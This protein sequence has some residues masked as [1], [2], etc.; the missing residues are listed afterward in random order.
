MPETLTKYG[1][2]ASTLHKLMDVF[3]P[4]PTIQTIIL[5]GSRAK[6]TYQPGSDI[7]LCLIAPTLTIEEQLQLENQID[8]LL[9]PW[10]VDLTVQHRIDSENLLKHIKRVGVIF[11]NF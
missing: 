7:D 4:Y 1:I 10:K 11:S 5:Y 3:K 8:D 6:G 2:P 9:L